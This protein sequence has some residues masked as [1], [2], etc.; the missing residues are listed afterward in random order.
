MLRMKRI[1]VERIRV[2]DEEQCKEERSRSKKSKF[3]YT[4]PTIETVSKVFT[5]FKSSKCLMNTESVMS[6]EKPDVDKVY[7]NIVEVGEIKVISDLDL[8]E[9]VMLDYKLPGYKPLNIVDRKS[10]VKNW[11]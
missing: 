6:V 8:V 11:I 10:C 1:R 2:E 5:S 4:K 9:V 3:S 7:D